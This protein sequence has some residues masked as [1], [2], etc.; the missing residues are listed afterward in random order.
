MRSLRPLQPIVRPVFDYTCVDFRVFR[1]LFFFRRKIT[2]FY[3]VLSWR[4]SELIVNFGL[5]KM[6]YRFS[7]E[8]TVSGNVI[9]GR[10]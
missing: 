7:V 4:E 6:E 9:N 1:S 8:C 10:L 3:N 5:I 2:L